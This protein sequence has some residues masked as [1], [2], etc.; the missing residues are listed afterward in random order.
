MLRFSPDGSELWFIPPEKTQEQELSF[1]LVY[2]HY[3]PKC[4]NLVQALFMTDKRIDPKPWEE[5]MTKQLD[6]DGHFKR[7]IPGRHER[8]R[9]R[10][11][12]TTI[13]RGNVISAELIRL[14]DHFEM[15]EDVSM[16]PVCNFLAINSAIPEYRLND[17]ILAHGLNPSQ[18]LVQDKDYEEIKYKLVSGYPGSD[19]YAFVPATGTGPELAIVSRSNQQWV[20]N[21][22]LG[23]H[24]KPYKSPIPQ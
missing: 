4:N 20:L 18:W 11:S 1:P 14:A 8:F 9:S 16:T 7:I 19:I 10:Y 23:N 17:L 2:G 13:G 22:A 3:C 6:K 24:L 15:K 12:I 21:M 5:I